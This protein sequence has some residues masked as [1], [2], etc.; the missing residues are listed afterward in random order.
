MEWFEDW[1]LLTMIF[2]LYG[3]SFPVAL[4]GI[5]CDWVVLLCQYG[6]K[7][8]PRPLAKV[9]SGIDFW[10]FPV[11]IQICRYLLLPMFKLSLNM[12]SYVPLE[13]CNLSIIVSIWIKRGPRQNT[14]ETILESDVLEIFPQEFEFHTTVVA[15]GVWMCQY[16]S[17]GWPRHR[18]SNIWPDCGSGWFGRHYFYDFPFLHLHL[19][20]FHD[21]Y[22]SYKYEIC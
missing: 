5:Y 6:S 22:Q 12:F 8:A 16:G 21:K 2:V 14:A 7:W 10:I 19:S 11:G 9:A 3:C 4:H 17:N 1:R 20:V 18:Q 15:P 13:A